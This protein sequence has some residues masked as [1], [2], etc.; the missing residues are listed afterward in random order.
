MIRGMRTGEAVKAA[1]GACLAL[2][3]FAGGC[4]NA[5]TYDIG[6]NDPNAVVAF[7]DSISA[8]EGSSN[9]LGYR[10]LL[11]NLFAA[12]G[13]AEI[14][15][16]DEGLP[17]A[18][19]DSGVRH[20]GT[21][22]QQHRPAV[23]VLLL[24]SNDEL[25][26]E[27]QHAFFG[28]AGTTSGN[29]RQIVTAARANNTLVVLSTIPPVCTEGRRAQRENIALMNEKIL[30]LAAEL[31]AQD[32][33]IFLA[34]AWDAFLTTGPPDGCGLINLDRGNHPNDA[35]YAVLAQTYYDSLRDARW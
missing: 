20:I 27:P 33:G 15:V 17:G 25:T 2:L 32:N 6:G 5:A 19:S 8:G 26:G 29:L 16:I 14:R 12:D 1:A 9:G 22:L 3:L 4:D 7:G 23:L 31:Q 24:G 28:F 13:R 34:D 30:A 11:K 18:F 35:G 10:G 21:V